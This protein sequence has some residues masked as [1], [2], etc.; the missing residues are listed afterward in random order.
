MGRKQWR[1]RTR[2]T[3]RQKGVKF[4]ID[5]ESTQT[6]KIRLP[7]ANPRDINV[8]VKVTIAPTKEMR[9]RRKAV[10]AARAKPKQE[11]R[12]IGILDP[13]THPLRVHEVESKIPL[14]APEGIGREHAVAAE[15][16]HQEVTISGKEYQPRAMEEACK[17]TETIS[18]A[19]EKRAEKAKE[20]RA[21]KR[22]EKRYQEQKAEKEKERQK[23]ERE[24]SLQKQEKW[25]KEQEDKRKAEAE[26]RRKANEERA[27][28]WG[29][30]ADKKSSAKDAPK[31]AE[32][33]K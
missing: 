21:E 26:K 7:K 16:V 30:R 4:L 29:L 2:G 8:N 10:E 3:A 15:G 32:K 5:G 12:P 22:E 6:K 33:H 1:T 24:E 19:M 23:K 14:Q 28:K 27:K 11:E 18:G 20:R 13:R 9:E 25:K 31:V 17:L